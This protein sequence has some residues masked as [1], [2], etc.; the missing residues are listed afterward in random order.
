MATG[1]MA[2]ADSIHSLTA[3][4]E[5]HAATPSRSFRVQP[6]WRVVAGVPDPTGGDHGPAGSYI[7]STARIWI[8]QCQMDLRQVRVE[9]AGGALR[10]D[11]TTAAV[12]RN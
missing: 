6:G 10:F 4:V 1:A 8:G 3:W 7:H 2:D 12:T 5:G 9:S 11:L